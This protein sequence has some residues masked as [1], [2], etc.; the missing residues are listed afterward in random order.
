MQRGG[1]VSKIIIVIATITIPTT[2]TRERER[3]DEEGYAPRAAS[4]GVAA[5]LSATEVSRIF[6]RWGDSNPTLSAIPNATKAN[7]PPWPVMRPVWMAAPGTIPNNSEEEVVMKDL[8]ATMPTRMARMVGA[9]LTI[10]FK[11]I[12]NP[13][14]MKKKPSS[15]PEGG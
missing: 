5:M 1:D 14:V 15:R 9:S 6:L 11:S 4:A 8:P 12:E 7:S 10:N 2:I 13:T 3:E